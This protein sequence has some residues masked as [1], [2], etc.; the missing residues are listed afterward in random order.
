MASDGVYIEFDDN[1]T[2]PRARK[3]LYSRGSS[4]SG[5]EAGTRL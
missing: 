2:R 5:F 4:N 3:K 1:A